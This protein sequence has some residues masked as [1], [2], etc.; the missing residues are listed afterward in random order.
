MGCA[1]LSAT[2]AQAQKLY[3]ISLKDFKIESKDIDFTVSEIIDARNDKNT[4]GIIQSGLN[5]RYVL[6]AFESPGLSEVDQLL[7]NS[8]LYSLSGISLRIN[9]LKISE[10]TSLIKET[11]K[12]ELNIDF[13]VRH[14]DR[15]YYIS[16]VFTSA[17]PGGVD[18]T[19]MQ[20]ANVVSL[21]EKALTIF[22][23]QKREP[24]PDRSFALED[25][26]DPELKL[27]DTSSMPVL[28]SEILNEGYF[29]SFDEFLNN[30]PSIPIDC[31]IK[32][33]TPVRAM[34]DEAITEVPTLYGFSRENKLYILYHREFYALEKRNGTFY[35]HGPSKISKSVT[36]ALTTSYFGT[37]AIVD[38]ELSVRGKYS[39]LF[40]LDM[41]TGMVRNMTGF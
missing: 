40:M 24:D 36:K 22:S 20:A 28:T 5:N 2:S 18:V 23:Q 13:F 6:A 29:A 41:T 17:E 9:V 33:S 31:R 39:G 15:Y 7:K 38:R 14:A 1:L 12:A 21:V 35:F 8:G 30:S 19:G 11:G 16:S 27:R 10:N 25:L 34:C 32:L 3:K 4:I 26:Q 37:M